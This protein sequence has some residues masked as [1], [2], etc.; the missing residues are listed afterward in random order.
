LSL[1]EYPL[2]KVPGSK[3]SPKGPWFNSATH[4][5][6]IYKCGKGTCGKERMMTVEGEKR[7]GMEN[8]HNVIYMSVKFPKN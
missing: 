6:K 5:T 4:K 8:N 2:V 3:W 1:V 7:V